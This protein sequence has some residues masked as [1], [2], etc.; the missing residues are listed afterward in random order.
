[1]CH[2]LVALAQIG[3]ARP[4]RCDRPGRLRPERHWS[5]SADL[6]AADPD[7]LVPVADA[8]GH[9]VDE[10]LV[11]G[12]RRRLIHLEDLNGLAERFDPGHPLGPRRHGL[13][14]ANLEHDLATL[15]AGRESL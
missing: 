7:K 8:R 12:R 9:D 6:A 14:V 5:R 15:P 3:H 2:Y 1:M 4:G 11:G 13:V 10:Y